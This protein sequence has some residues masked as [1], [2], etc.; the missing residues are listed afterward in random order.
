MIS[1]LSHTVSSINATV[2]MSEERYGR[3]SSAS[4]SHVLVARS[5]TVCRTAT[6]LPYVVHE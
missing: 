2:A 6:S 5:H 3:D 4:N 1:L